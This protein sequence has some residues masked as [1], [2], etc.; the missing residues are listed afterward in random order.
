MNDS[1]SIPKRWRWR[2]P[3][4]TGN[5]APGGNGEC[6]WA[7][8]V[9]PDDELER[10]RDEANA[11]GY[12]DIGEFCRKQIVMRAGRDAFV[13]PDEARQVFARR[14]IGDA[15]ELM[16]HSAAL[17][18]L[19]LQELALAGVKQ[20]RRADLRDVLQPWWVALAERAHELDADAGLPPD[21]SAVGMAYRIA[22][23]LEH[24][25]PETCGE[26]EDM[27]KETARCHVEHRPLYIADEV[28]RDFARA[29]GWDLDIW[30]QK[31]GIELGYDL[32]CKVKRL[33]RDQQAGWK[34]PR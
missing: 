22:M 34:R 8:A 4:A 33:G 14:R 3:R 30:Q 12:S 7:L 32:G 19:N 24:A 6:R 28:R 11:A 17:D 29:V 25:P 23:L 26:L 21:R 20:V 13:L 5:L 18:W 1:S 16:L 2:H 15:A 27:A 31:S 9:E 10:V